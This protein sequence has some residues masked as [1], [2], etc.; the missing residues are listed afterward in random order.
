[1]AASLRVPFSKLAADATRNECAVKQFRDFLRIR[2]ISSEGPK[3]SYAEAVSFL[4]A[5]ATDYGFQTKTVEIVKNKPILI[6]SWKGKDPKMSSLMLNSHYDVVPVEPLSWNYSPFEAFRSDSGNIYARGAQDMKCVSIQTLHAVARLKEGGFEA[7]RDIHM[8]FVPDEEL[9]GLEGMK[10]FV[11]DPSFAALNVG[12]VLDEG[13]ANPTE[14]FT[15]FY[16]ERAPWWLKIK[17]TGNVGHASRFIEGTAVIKL[18]KVID[19]IMEYRSTQ[20]KRLDPD[21]KRGDPVKLGDVTTVNCTRLVAG[22]SVSEGEPYPY[23]VIPGLAEAGFDFRLTPHESHRDVMKM[24]EDWTKEEGVSIEFVVKT[25]ESLPT[26]IESGMYRV[27]HDAFE[28]MG[29]RPVPEIFPA[30][31]DARYLREKGIPAL[32]FSPINN[33]PILLH[34]NDEFLNEKVFVDGIGIYM[35]IIDSLASMTNSPS[36][37]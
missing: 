26:S 14:R 12:M 10:L 4:K 3:G 29:L 33:T 31:T 21:G 9:G 2:T 15:V 37:I 23:N 35:E 36:E 22:P 32:G 28:R 25:P 1:M 18:Q 34:D 27:F 11:E 8:T 19:R 24:L 17:A 5:L 6:A 13:L 20:E 30:A 16:G 7:A